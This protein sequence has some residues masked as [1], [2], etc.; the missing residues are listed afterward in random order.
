MVTR[1]AVVAYN[2]YREAVRA[3]VL[4]GLLALSLATGGYALIV[5]AFSNRAHLRVVSDLGAA[6]ISIYGVV[7][8]VVLGATALYRELE[9]KTIFP[10]LAR[11]IYRA[12]Y[13]VGK[14]LGTALTL[15][16]FVA[17]DT[18]A[19]LLA[20]AQLSGRNGWFCTGL[21]LGG[22][23]LFAILAWRLPRLRTLLPIPFA[24]ALLVA[25]A[26]L[27]SGAPDDRN[28]LLGSALLTLCEVG[29]VAA[30]ATVFAGFSSPFLT[31]IFT[32]GV[33]VV[34]RSADTLGNLPARMF[35]EGVRSLGQ[36]VSKVVPNLMLYVPERPLLTG[37]AAGASLLSYL[38]LAL[39]HT[40]CWVVG[41]LTLSS[42]IF[43][44]RDFL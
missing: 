7:V 5:G 40:V 19:L 37:E 14:Y 11:P 3:R 22:V 24:F 16:V 15:A 27:A 28:V 13:L 38:G 43:R 30:I 36:A 35:G 26:L 31:A 34:G 2:T 17:A 18:G 4:H 33:F 8:A 12:E 10:I 44:R 21:G 39:V 20:L 42:L 32:F 1:V 25:G 29:L 23:A 6:S 9:L 41:L